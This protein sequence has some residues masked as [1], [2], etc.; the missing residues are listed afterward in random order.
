MATSLV[1][2]D[3]TTWID[4]RK[5]REIEL[6]LAKVCCLGR[7][8]PKKRRN[9]HICSTCISNRGFGCQYFC[10]ATLSLMSFMIQQKKLVPYTSIL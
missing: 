3:G 10:L 5:M 1:R 6:G 9:Q 4:F 2:D 7:R 8:P